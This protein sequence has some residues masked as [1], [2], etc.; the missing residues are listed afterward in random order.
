MEEYVDAPCRHRA[1]FI[2]CIEQGKFWR[3]SET[4]VYDEVR[5]ISML[6]DSL[7]T[8]FLYPNIWMNIDDGNPQDSINF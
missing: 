4:W 6:P 8:T 1:L 5:D 7:T 3:N 2:I